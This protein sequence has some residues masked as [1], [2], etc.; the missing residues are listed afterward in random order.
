MS[1]NSEWRAVANGFYEVNALGSVRRAVAGKG[2]RVGHVLKQSIATTG[3]PVVS[4]CIDGRYRMAYVHAL[5]AQAFIGPR[6][7]G[8]Q[9]N[10]I[11]GIKTNPGAANLE[12]VT[13]REN[14]EH[15]GRMGLVPSGARHWTRRSA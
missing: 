15:A 3:Y 2:A 1:D 12:Y 14:A 5:V 11:D 7:A 8:M 13:H 9:I 6:P 4:V 10:H